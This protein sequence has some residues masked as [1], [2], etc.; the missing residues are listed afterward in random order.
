MTY[1]KI[2]KK[3]EVQR[4]SIRNMRRRS[5]SASLTTPMYSLE[6]TSVPPAIPTTLLRRDVPNPFPQHFS[7]NTESSRESF[8]AAN[9]LTWQLG[10]SP[11]HGRS[12]V[13]A[14]R[15][16]CRRFGWRLLSWPRRT[17]SHRRWSCLWISVR[18]TPKNKKFWGW[19]AHHDHL[20]FNK[21][22]IKYI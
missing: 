16:Y 8:S 1:S 4:G 15:A 10:L 18:R 9:M 19:N 14:W 22:L 21:N 13:P 11:F 5:L 7:W 17:W 3:P 20:H 12:S 2:K 6:Q